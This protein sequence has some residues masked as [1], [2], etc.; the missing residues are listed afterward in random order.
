[1]KGKCRSGIWRKVCGWIRI[2][3][4]SVNKPV[5]LKF[6]VRMSMEDLEATLN[7]PY[8]SVAGHSNHWAQK[9]PELR[10]LLFYVPCICRADPTSSFSLPLLVTF[11]NES[12]SESG[13]WDRTASRTF[14]K[15]VQWLEL[16]G[17]SSSFQEKGRLRGKYVSCLQLTYSTH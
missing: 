9:Q 2:N 11:A 3:G 1:M 5:F 17:W 4:L 10:I 6:E 13:S 12:F 14:C 7:H 16:L 8:N 15:F